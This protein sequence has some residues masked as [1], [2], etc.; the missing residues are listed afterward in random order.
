MYN[1]NVERSC[2]KQS[3]SYNK[4]NAEIVKMA[5]KHYNTGWV[6]E[7]IS[8][9]N[10]KLNKGDSNIMKMFNPKVKR[11]RRTYFWVAW[12]LCRIITGTGIYVTL[13]E[14]APLDETFSL[15]WGLLI[16][17]S[18]I[19]IVC[20]SLLTIK[21]YHDAGYGTG[22]AVLSL[23]LVPFVIGAFLIFHVAVMES[24]PDNEWGPNTER[25]EYEK[26]RDFYAR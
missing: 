20:F 5:K 18:L 3:K 2:K 22:Y 26:N 6:N 24:E 11:I 23:L 21:R 16:L 13:M 1:K 7:D 15:G 9:S 8:Y 19:D 17:F 4:S 12:I 10:I 25:L 14:L